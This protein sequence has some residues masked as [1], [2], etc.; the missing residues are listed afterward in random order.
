MSLSTT[1][2]DTY[3]MSSASSS[4]SAR[5]GASAQTRANMTEEEDD[6]DEQ[7]EAAVAGLRIVTELAPDNWKREVGDDAVW[8]LSSAKP[9]N[10]VE[11]LRDGRTDTFWQ[12]VSVDREHSFHPPVASSIFISHGAVYINLS[13]Y[14]PSVIPFISPSFSLTCTFSPLI[15]FLIISHTF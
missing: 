11:Q 14:L 15:R 7:V 4:S 10:G 5:P 9:G 2:L 13:C 8:S 6:N 1:F 3:A 12:Y